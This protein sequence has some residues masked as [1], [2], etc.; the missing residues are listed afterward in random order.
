MKDQLW[1]SPVTGRLRRAGTRLKELRNLFESGISARAIF[2]R[3]LCCLSEEDAIEIS[4]V[5]SGKGFDVAGVQEAP[6]GPVIGF[7][8]RDSLQDGIVR[9]HLNQMT[10]EHLISDATPLA[11][12][13]SIF[14]SKDRVFVLVGQHV[15]GIV[16]KADLDKPPMRL[17][18]FGLISL[19]EMHLTYW[20][21]K[22]YPSEEW[23]G[24][25]TPDRL[26]KAEDLRLDRRNQ[27]KDRSHYQL[28]RV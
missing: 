13:L 5:L 20:I 8:F 23:K 21:K 19:L 9:N 4:K 7:V 2:E 28:S 17:Y 22:A 27:C 16:T 1:T 6:N 15:V 25:L 10:S 14:K 11:S 26:Q 18:L 3:L 12:L 24:I